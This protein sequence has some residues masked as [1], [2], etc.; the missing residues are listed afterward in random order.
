MKTIT[1]GY[2]AIFIEDIPPVEAGAKAAA[3]P[4]REARRASFIFPVLLSR[5]T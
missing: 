3:A 4:M 1:H 5:R 2:L